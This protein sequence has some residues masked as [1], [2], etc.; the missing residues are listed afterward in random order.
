MIA[1]FLSLLAA[2]LLEGLIAGVPLA[3]RSEPA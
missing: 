3:R 1:G 2:A